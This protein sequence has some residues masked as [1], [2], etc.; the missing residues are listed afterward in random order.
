MR[1]QVFKI[2]DIN[3]FAGLRDGQ[4]ELS[5]LFYP[6]K[7]KLSIQAKHFPLVFSTTIT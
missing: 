6:S 5:A 4:L 2:D 7:K 3:A 1:E